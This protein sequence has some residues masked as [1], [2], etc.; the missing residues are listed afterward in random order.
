[1]SVIKE[2]TSP[3][4]KEE[5]SNKCSFLIYSLPWDMASSLILEVQITKQFDLV[6]D[7]S[8]NFL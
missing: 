2:S 7:S 1:M 4:H 6:K 5:L 3:E 8:L